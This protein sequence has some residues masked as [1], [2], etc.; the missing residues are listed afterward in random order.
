M[1]CSRP[2][3]YLERAIDHPADTRPCPDL[4]MVTGDLVDRGKPTEYARLR[5]LLARLPM[6]VYVLPGN[7]DNR[8]AMRAAFA[9]TGYMPADGFLHYTIED[10][11]LRLIALD[12]LILGQGRRPAVRRAHRLDRRPPRRAARP[13]DRAVHASPAVPPRS[14]ISTASPLRR[15]GARCRAQA[16]R[17]CRAGDLRP[18]PS[19]HPG[20]LR[21]HHR[22][23]TT[24][25]TA[26]QAILELRPD[27]PSEFELA[28]PGFALH[29]WS[30][31]T[32]CAATSSPSAR[33]PAP[34]SSTRQNRAAGRI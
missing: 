23:M 2:R 6:P 34:I 3:L 13:A 10:R 22:A 28:P 9:D 26:H 30:A 18:H 21:R 31:E 20:P 16:L 27:G 25:S 29:H 33:I 12:T 32:A 1:A 5:G 19:R 8:D 15:A 17:Q 14:R 24:P 7:H 4:V 11:P